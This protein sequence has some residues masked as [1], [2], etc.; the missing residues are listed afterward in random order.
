MKE[1]LFL[2]IMLIGIT[3]LCIPSIIENNEVD[4]DEMCEEV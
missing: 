3:I 4:E 1:L 2:V